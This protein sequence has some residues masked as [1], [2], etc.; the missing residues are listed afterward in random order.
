MDNLDKD[1]V[2]PYKSLLIAIIIMSCGIITQSSCNSEPKKDPVDSRP[3]ISNIVGVSHVS[4]KY[5]LTD[6]DFLNEG[7]DQIL[8]LGSRVIK[9]WLHKGYAGAYPFNS[10]W[11]TV[12]SMTELVKTPYFETMID[13]PFTTIVFEAFEF[14]SVNWKDGISETEKSGIESEFYELTKYL[15]TRY[16][17][18]GKTF[19]LQNWEGDNA[20]GTNSTPV[21]IQGMIDWLNARQ[22]GIEKARNETGMH[23]VFVFGCAEVNKIPCK[24]NSFSYPLVVDAVIPKTHCDIYSF[25]AWFSKEPGTEER[26][27]EQLDYLAS[28][29]PPSVF[30]E[31]KNIM[32]GEFGCPESLASKYGESGE[33]QMENV[34][35]QLKLALDWGVR[36]AVYWQLYCNE[37]KKN[38]NYIK[39]ENAPAEKLNGFWLIRPDGSK[40]PLW[41][42]LNNLLT[43]N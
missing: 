9:V 6:K 13:N 31:S 30:F 38:T 26:I 10:Q 25:S 36:Y 29:A 27:V 1:I 24:G 34:K 21:M 18:T 2:L 19:I 16:R 22:T 43:L 12:N 39:G 20:I 37:I 35:K 4:G 15:L 41:H 23:G 11:P 3:S 28:K 33:V 14:C 40:T 8:A 7:A 17:D 42:Y 32:I 5:H